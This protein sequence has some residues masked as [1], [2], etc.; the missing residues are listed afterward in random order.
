MTAKLELEHL[1]AGYDGQPV[2]SGVSL[3]LGEGE[4]GCLTGPSGCGKTT[5]LRAVA[6][7]IRP[8]AGEVR[9]SGE[10]V[11]RRDYLRPVEQRRVGM[12]FQDYALFPH[13]DVHA[14]IAFGLGHYSR[15]QR[16]ERV[17][18]LAELLSIGEL[19]GQ[20]PH[21]LSGGQ[22]QRVALA[23]ALAPRPQLMLLDEPF[24]S[25][26][27]E[28]REDLA[29]EVGAILRR[30]RVTAVMVT[31]NQL[32][33]FAMADRVGVVHA[34]QLVQWDTPF[35]L[36]HRPASRFV[37]GFIGEGVFIP[38]RVRDA[39][40]VETELG[41]L[42]AREPHGLAA[43][44]EV[45]VLVR[46][47]DIIHDDASDS[48]AVVVEKAFRGAEFLYTLAL[49]SGTRLQSLVPSHHNHPVNQAIGIRAD[50]EHL[51]VFP[52]QS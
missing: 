7:F 48:A 44:S 47:D 23:R 5:L 52:R 50:I 39:H 13:L 32:E 33:A 17:A 2:I 46:P 34:G 6:G 21:Q 30:D 37:A 19:L 14:N 51:V 31:H 29:R 20:Y 8:L 24:S 15:T 43:A 28:L 22:Q 38:G 27:V 42:A 3:V 36:Y 40:R 11:S 9:I 4:I 45:E 18:E 1:G 35:E 49:D 41:L 25:M 26:D 16:R 12:V 10:V